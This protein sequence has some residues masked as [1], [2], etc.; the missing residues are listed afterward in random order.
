MSRC[1]TV[2]AI[3]I[4]TATLFVTASPASADEAAVRKAIASYVEAFNRADAKAVA[5]H[6]TPGGEFVTPGGKSLKGR[7]ALQKEFEAYFAE[8][9]NAKVDV[10]SAQIRVLSPGVAVEEGTARVLV[11]GNEPHETNYVAVHVKSS[12]GWKMDSVREQ[13]S[14]KPRSH[15]EQLKVLEWMVGDWA[16]DSDG[17]SVETSCQWTKNRNFLTRAFKVN[18]Q[19]R[20]ELEGTQVIGWDPTAKTIRSWVFDSEGGFGVGVW[21]QNGSQW[22]VRTLQVMADG[23]RASSINLLNQVDKNTFTFR[24]VSREV[25]G[26]LQPNVD[27]IKVVRK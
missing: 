14:V 16:D 10:T 19:G 8:T 24:S 4:A 22:T 3:G 5:E 1:L 9:K 13:D 23:Q 20:I 12:D 15:Y 25:A 27:E 21:S 11:P 7:A 2:L 6:W 18:V 26:Q 17:A